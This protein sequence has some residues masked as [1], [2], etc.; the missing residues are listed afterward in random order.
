MIMGHE[1]GHLLGLDE[2]GVGTWSIMNN[3][4]WTGSCLDSAQT[5]INNG[6]PTGPTSN[7]STTMDTCAYGARSQS[8]IRREPANYQDNYTNP[9]CYE[10]W[11]IWQWYSCTTSYCWPTNEEWIYQGT[12]CGETGCDD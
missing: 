10:R 3:P 1:I 12:Y 5:Q 4:F 7:D 6:G 8:P 2:E 11:E 9:P